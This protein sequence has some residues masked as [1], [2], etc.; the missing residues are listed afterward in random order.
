MSG[1]PRARV[2]FLDR[3]SELAL[4]RDHLTRPGASMF[5]LHGRRRIGK[6]ALLEEALKALPRAAFII[7]RAG[8]TGR[9]RI[10]RDERLID[11]SRMPL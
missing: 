3:K 5:V 8:F 7:S 4:L 11:V 2:R 10:G 9:R 1:V 6:T